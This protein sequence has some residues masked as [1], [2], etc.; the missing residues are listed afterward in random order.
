MSIMR[1]LFIVP[2]ALVLI[3]A[4]GHSALWLYAA[5]RLKDGFVAWTRVQASRG[6][7]IEHG[8]LALSGFPGPIKLAI[9]APHYA[10]AKTGWQWSAERA[11]LE[12]RPWDWWTY[13]LDIFGRQTLALPFEGVPPQLSGEA[14]ST[15]VIAKVD[16][17]GRVTQAALTVDGLRL[18]DAENE[19]VS[20]ATIRATAHVRGTGA[21]PHDEA[22]L[23]LWLQAKSLTLG[24]PVQSPLGPRLDEVNLSASVKGALPDT[25]RR[26]S[27]DGWRR[28]G[29][30][31]ELTH[32][33]IAWGALELNATG[34][35]ALDEML[36]PLGAVSAEIKGYGET[37]SALE[38]AQVVPPKAAAGSRLALD[39][40]SR[41]DGADGRRVVTIPVSAQN[42]ALYLGPIRLVRLEPIPF[43]AR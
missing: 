38:A 15:F 23:D 32:F 12:M 41:P 34:T 31:V 20:A 16:G 10:S 21:V 13:R 26:E 33:H 5:H 37:L 42:G 39:L 4:V 8:P 18:G 19:L 7:A 36:R 35:M 25:L 27:V 40:L 24:P 1:R 29:G 3:L 22:A 28:D 11:T 14:A 6:H 9:D 2:A 17:R 30:T 43:P